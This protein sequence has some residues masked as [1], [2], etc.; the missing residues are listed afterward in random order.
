MIVVAVL[1]VCLFAFE[2]WRHLSTDRLIR[3]RRTARVVIELHSGE[4]FRGVLTACDARSLTL[5]AA[6]QVAA[7]EIPVDGDLLLPRGDVKFV[8]RP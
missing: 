1:V 3:D 4:T 5:G 7:T 6:T 2:A 8:Q